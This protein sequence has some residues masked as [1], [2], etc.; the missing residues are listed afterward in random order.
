MSYNK[1]GK[2]FGGMTCL[3]VVQIL[4]L[5]EILLDSWSLLKL[6]VQHLTWLV[7][8]GAQSHTR[9]LSKLV[10]FFILPPDDPEV[11]MEPPSATTTTTIGISATWT[12]LA[13][14]HGKRNN[15]I[16]TTSSKRK[17]RKNKVAPDNVQIIFDDQLPISYNQPEKVNGE[18]KSSST[19]ESGDSDNMRI[20]SC[21]DESSNSNSSHKS[22]NHSSTAVTNTQS[23][24][25]QP[26]VLVTCP[27][28]EKKAVTGKSSIK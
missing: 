4:A 3:V 10:L 8:F 13:G 28:D 19:S 12:T 17:N 26:S 9:F 6:F 11:P 18:S 5:L 1:Q 22:D 24:K 16:T 25:K 20:S 27:K 15:T 21:S 7:L 14:S 2:K 23:N